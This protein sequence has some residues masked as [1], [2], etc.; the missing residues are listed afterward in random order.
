MNFELKVPFVRRIPEFQIIVPFWRLKKLLRMC[1]IGFHTSTEHYPIG[2][3]VT[4]WN[5]RVVTPWV[6]FD[7]RRNY[8][9]Q[10]TLCIVSSTFLGYRHVPMRNSFDQGY[11]YKNLYSRR[12]VIVD[13]SYHFGRW[14]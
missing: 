4:G 6:V 9:E 11:E 14:R 5:F 13:E 12:T 7:T 1:Y 3:S 10:N 2:G 8:G